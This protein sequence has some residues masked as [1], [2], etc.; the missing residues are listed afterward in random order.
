[1][2][3]VQ[4]LTKEEWDLIRDGKTPRALLLV[5]NR[6]GCGLREAKDLVDRA[7]EV[8]PKGPPN[9]HRPLTDILEGML[10]G[11]D[12]MEYHLK[13]NDCVQADRIRIGL[14]EQTR[15]ALRGIRGYI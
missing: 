12:N 6:L 13:A 2:S 3:L 10:N 14:Q 11:L 8:F 7:R 5:R 4:G 1:M 9:V 15:E